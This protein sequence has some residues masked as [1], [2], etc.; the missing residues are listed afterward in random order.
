LADLGDQFTKGFDK[1]VNVIGDL[2]RYSSNLYIGGEFVMAGDS[3]AN[4]IVQLEN[5]KWQ[6]LGSGLNAPCF[7]LNG[8][9]NPMSTPLGYYNNHLFVGGSFMQAGMKISNNFAVWGAAYSGS[10]RGNTSFAESIV[11]S[12]NPVQK[13]A[14]I[15]FILPERMDIS[16]SIMDV[17]GRKVLSLAKGFYEAGK[18]EVHFDTQSL[19]VGIYYC[20]LQAGGRSAVVPL[21]HE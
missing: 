7:A 8:Y 15:S 14:S 16:I 18:Y 19:P 6:T 1:A 10:V 12:P 3:S 13:S 20:R 11:V 5:N 17:L 21:I 2:G 4:H 9:F